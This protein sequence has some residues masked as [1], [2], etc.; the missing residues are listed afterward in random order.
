[1]LPATGR[2][3]S[4]T[5]TDKNQESHELQIFHEVAKALTSSLDLDAALRII[6]DKA[7]AYFKPTT[8]ALLLVDE[9]SGE[10]YYA[11]SVGQGCDR[12]N[13][14]KLTTGESLAR[15][16]VEKGEALVIGDINRDGRIDPRSK[17]E[18]FLEPC[19]V[20]CMPV[21]TSGKTLGLMQLLNNAVPMDG[22]G[23]MLLQTLADYA[24][25]AIENARSVERIRELIITDDCTGLYNDRHLATVL[26]E[27]L[28]RSQRFGYEFS[29][30]FLDL[31]DFKQ[32][33]DKYGHP[34]GSKLLGEVGRW[35]RQNLRLVDSAF[36]YGGDEFVVL[37]PQTG[38][39]AAIIAARRLQ[40]TFNRTA[41]LAEEGLSV[42]LS[43]S[44]GIANYPQDGDSSGAIVQRADEL[45]YAVKQAGR[46][47]IAATGFGI[48]GRGE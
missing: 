36:R 25:L 26:A 42:S 22:H 44:I 9:S 10:L 1:M 45:M 28:S 8:W 30:L 27:E 17:D 11:M 6:V 4:S 7:A 47:N 19:S 46:N 34:T 32:V 43:A 38:K 3:I 37:L 24:A 5:M 14:L 29:L 16:V 41:W 39:T 12:V 35:L 2:E 40:K 21:C 48:V 31:D 18:S 15:W 23:A 20:V 33:N 13:A